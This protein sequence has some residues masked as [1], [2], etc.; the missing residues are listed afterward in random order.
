MT[1]IKNIAVLG[2]SGSTGVHIVQAL[3]DAS[4]IVTIVRRPSSS[5]APPIISAHYKVADYDSISSL[6]AAFKDQDAVVESFNP[7]AAASQNNILAA[8]VAAGVKHI[9]TP[10]FSS[11]T[12]NP[13][14]AGLLIF[15]P[16]LKAQKE[17]EAVAAEGKLTWTAIIPGAFYDWGINRGVFWINKKSHTITV[18]GSGN[19]RVSMSSIAIC[20][21][22]TVEVLQD[23]TRFKNR[24]AYFADYTVSTN[25][26]ESLVREATSP[27][28]WEVVHVSLSGFFDKALQ[29]WE[30]DT[31]N[32]VVDR[33]NSAAYPMLGTYALFHEDNRYGADFSEMAEPGWTK[34]TDELKEELKTILAAP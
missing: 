20:G 15:E 17:L 11:D 19:Q 4:F 34:S 32:G 26:L 7:A 9:I 12:F 29:M 1:K 3:I 28:S 31:K 27:Q 5:P 6:E 13:H 24:P 23:I 10:D 2:A 14:A 33:L 18:F 21:K 30:E 16:K 25:E 22:A 8:A